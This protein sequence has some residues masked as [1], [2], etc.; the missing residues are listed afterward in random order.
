VFPLQL[1]GFDVDVVNSVHL[2]NHTGYG[3]VRGDVLRGEQLRAILDGLQRNDLLADT[4][5]IL[6]GYIGSPS[7][8]EAVVDVVVTVR[9]TC[10]TSS[11][12]S[13]TSAPVR[14]V[15]D[16]V[17][18]DRGQLY[19]PVELVQLYRDKI[20]PIADVITPNQFEVEQLTGVPTIRT[21]SDAKTACDILHGIG[22]TVVFITS[23]ELDDDEDD[24]SAASN[25]TD[26]EEV[27]QGVTGK[28]MAILASERINV[29]KEDFGEDVD[30]TNSNSNHQRQSTTTTTTVRWKVD[31]PVLPGHF[32]GTGDLCAALLLAHTARERTLPVAM[33]K[34]INT[35]FAVLQ[36][37]HEGAGETVKSRELRLIQ[38][39]DLI[40]NPPHTFKAHRIL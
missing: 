9:N 27:N 26:K 34:V 2:S 24:N 10:N 30:D 33:E 31:C 13:T 39:K 20:L 3:T 12:T 15:C 40:E 8:L 11:N 23:L 25:G 28:T 22:P 21:L 14:Y 4:G 38:S 6:T 32:T 29:T 18:G 16:P 1:L 7:F 17:L 5:H 36:R 35:M 37:T 19:V